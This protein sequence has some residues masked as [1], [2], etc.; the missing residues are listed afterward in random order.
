MNRMKNVIRFIVVSAAIA[1]ASMPR[2]SAEDPLKVAV[3]R[4]GGWESAPAELGQQ[5]GMFKKHGIVLDIVYFERSS[6]VERR[7][8]SGSAE[9]GLAVGAMQ[10]MRAYAFGAPIRIIGATRTGSPNYWYVLKSSPIRSFKDISGKTVAYATNGSSSHYDAID[11]TGEFRLRA[12]LVPTGG[13]TAT[14]NQLKLGHI[15][16]AWAAAPFGIDEVELGNIRVLSRANDVSSIRYKTVSVMITNVHTLQKRRDVLTRFLQAYRD[17]IEWMYSDP[18]ALQRSAEFAGVSEGVARR[19]RDEFFIKD[20]LWPDKIVRAGMI[21]KDAVKLDYL[22][23]ALSR[24][25]VRELIQI[26]TPAWKSF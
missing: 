19:M 7:V 18:A 25:Q 24:R 1:L 3:A 10:V 21:I 22:Q 20:M 26:A 8:I 9:V 14:L 23:K 4:H 12:K 15:D 6:E 13:P 16:V 11:L 17:T 5:A 2:A